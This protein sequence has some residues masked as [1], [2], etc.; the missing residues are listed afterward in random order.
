MKGGKNVDLDTLFDKIDN[1]M[2]VFDGRQ[3]RYLGKP[4]SILV[5]FI[6]SVSRQARQVSSTTYRC[7]FPVLT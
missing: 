7:R 5:D 6:V 1:F 4:L 2:E 3:A